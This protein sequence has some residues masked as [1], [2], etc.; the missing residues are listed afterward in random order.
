MGEFRCLPDTWT[1]NILISAHIKNNND[2]IAAKYLARMKRA[3]LE[4]NVELPSLIHILASADKP[5]DAKSYLLR[6]Q[7]VGL[8]SDRVPYCVVIKSFVKLGQ[9]K[10]AEE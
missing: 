1:Y 2:N 10:M 3:C 4:P 5:H 6:M 9:L 8:V 7:D